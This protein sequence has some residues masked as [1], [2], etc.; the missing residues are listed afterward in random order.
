MANQ[1]P[2]ADGFPPNEPPTL[3][4]R[5]G[6][7]KWISHRANRQKLSEELFCHEDIEGLQAAQ[8][9]DLRTRP[10]RMRQDASSPVAR[11]QPSPKPE[12]YRLTP[13]RPELPRQL[14]PRVR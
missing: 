1:P 11:P 4:I 6:Q 14:F 13:A 5:N 7:D 9:G 12:A 8:N 2:K 10:P 3:T